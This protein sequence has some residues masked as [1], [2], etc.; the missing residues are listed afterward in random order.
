MKDKTYLKFV[1]DELVYEGIN[2]VSIGDMYWKLDYL[3]EKY[4][5]E[6]EDFSVLSKILT[7]DVENV[8]S[9]YYQ[10]EYNDD[11]IDIYFVPHR[12]QEK[13][14]DEEAVYQ[15]SFKNCVGQLKENYSYVYDHI[16]A[17]V[18][19]QDKDGPLVCFEPVYSLVQAEK[20]YNDFIFKHAESTVN[21]M[22]L[23]CDLALEY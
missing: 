10:T 12:T 23:E 18:S 20:K 21:C 7:E 15:K 2:N 14:V 11:D 22:K 5:L 3:K 9:V 16:N 17:S 6:K 8:A 13:L 19:I 1:A 4:N